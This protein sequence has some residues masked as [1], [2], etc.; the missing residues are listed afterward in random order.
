MEIGTLVIGSELVTGRRNDEHMAHTIETL[1]KRGL[2]LSW[3]QVVG[4]SPDLLTRVLKSSMESRGIVFSFGGIGC[5]PDDHTPKQPISSFASS[6]TKPILTA[7]AWPIC[8]KGA[9]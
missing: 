4:D 1:A 3:C 8:P 6:A 2:E 5:T 9:S 7:S